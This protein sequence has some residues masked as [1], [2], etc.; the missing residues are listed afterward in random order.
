LLYVIVRRILL[1]TTSSGCKTE[2]VAVPHETMHILD[3]ND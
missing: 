2:L 3:D 1:C